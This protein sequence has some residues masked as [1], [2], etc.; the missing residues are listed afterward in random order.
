MPENIDYSR[1]AN[2]TRLHSAA[3]REKA[4]PAARPVPISL[5]AVVCI[6]AIGIMAGGYFGSN[7]GKNFGIANIQG[8]NYDLQF[9]EGAAGGAAVLSD[10]ELHQPENWKSAGK[11]I[12]SQC[13][14]CHTAS[15]EGQP[16]LYPPL[17][18]SEFVI[19]GEKR[20]VA[21]LQHGVTGALTVNGKPFN[22]QMQPLGAGMTDKQLAQLL[23]YIR[24]EWGNAASIIYEDQVNALR[25][26][27]GNRPSYSEAEL[28]AIPESAGAPASA[29][30]EK[31]K[32]TAAPAAPAAAK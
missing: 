7:T 27:L 20:L 9:P 13:V 3:A 29:W 21:I 15:G 23:S 17:K 10:E 14:A 8:Y 2:V 18:A 26:E 32:A 28:R 4:D 16:G 24:N 12:Y 30:P 1:T 31:L 5:W 6:G 22:G 11:A 25:K 19:H